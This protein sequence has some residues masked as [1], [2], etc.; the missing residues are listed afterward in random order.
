MVS[1][2]FGR[3]L[4]VHY[5]FCKNNLYAFNNGPFVVLYVRVPYGMS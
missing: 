1:I 5:S 2:P 3:Y 4:M